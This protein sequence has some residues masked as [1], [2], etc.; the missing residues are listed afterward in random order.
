MMLNTKQAAEYLGLS[1]V[2]LE[3]WRVRGGKISFLKL[4]KAVRYAQ[5]DLDAFLASHKKLNTSQSEAAR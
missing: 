2:T 3:A 4:G 5:S 1:P